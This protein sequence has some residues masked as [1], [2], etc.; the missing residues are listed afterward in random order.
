MHD[1]SQSSASLVEMAC[2]GI[3]MPLARVFSKT[4]L[5]KRV[6]GLVEG[7]G[8]EG[9]VIEVGEEQEWRRKGRLGRGG[10]G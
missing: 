3:V 7:G 5:E 4:K 6:A 8:W 9:R 10:G 2:S 1:A